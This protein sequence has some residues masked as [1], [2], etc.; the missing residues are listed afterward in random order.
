MSFSVYFF[1]PQAFQTIFNKLLTSFLYC[2]CIFHQ[3]KNQLNI[4]LIYRVR[5]K[6]VL[7]GVVSIT[8]RY[9]ASL[10][11]EKSFRLI[12]PKFLNTSLL[13]CFSKLFFNIQAQI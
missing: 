6:S 10:L 9:D 11:L 12:F 8:Y 4:W 5:A 1:F 13:I 7:Q 2:T 3:I